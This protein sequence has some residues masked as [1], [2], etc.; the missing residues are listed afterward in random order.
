MA[1]PEPLFPPGIIETDMQTLE[2]VCV[3]ERPNNETRASLFSRLTIY[4]QQLSLI[5]VTLHV[6][7]DGSFVTTKETPGDIDLCIWFNAKEMDGVNPDKQQLAATLLHTENKAQLRA[8]YG[9]DVYYAVH[10]DVNTRMYWRGCYGFIR[11]TEQAKGIP[12]IV[13]GG[14]NESDSLA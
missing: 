11:E 12:E 1:D 7:V 10:G 14:R 2:R 8:R 5:G 4:F 3:F 9:V 13:V 6:W